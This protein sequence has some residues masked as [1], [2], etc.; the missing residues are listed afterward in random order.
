M[1]LV[2]KFVPRSPLGAKSGS[3]SEMLAIM[4]SDKVDST[5]KVALRPT[6]SAAETDS[7]AGNEEI[8]HVGSCEKSTE[9]ASRE[10][11]E[12][13]VLLKPDMLEDMDTCA[14]FVDGV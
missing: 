10:A 5:A 7:P 4:K 11:A 3:L 8:V 9:L 6:S 12:I 2:P 14:K 13:C 1:P